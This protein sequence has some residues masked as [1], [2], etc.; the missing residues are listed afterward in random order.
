MTD[1]R[2]FQVRTGAG[3]EESRLNEDFIA[4][5]R[6][7]STPLLI[8]VAVAAGGFALYTR[9]T[10]AQQ[11]ELSVA[12]EELRAAGTGERPNPTSLIAVAEQYPKIKSVANLAR[13]QAADAYLRAVRQRV[14]LGA[15]IKAEDGSLLDAS[16]ILTDAL[17]EQYLNNAKEQYQLVLDATKNTPEKRL[18]AVA[19]AFGIAAVDES[20]GNF[21]DATAAYEETIRLSEAA[22][23][24]LH[25]EIAKKRLASLDTVKQIGPVISQAELP[26]PPA[27]PAPA[28]PA[29]LP[30]PAPAPTP[31]AVPAPTP[32]P[33]P[34]PT[35]EAAPATPAPAPTTPPTTPPD[36]PK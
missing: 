10:K 6:K 19:A 35:P 30:T 5:L 4:F 18:L 31:E 23:D 34:A 14:A 27:P 12:F 1:D 3:L 33:T 21:S 7:W 22:G 11:E 24:T 13:L 20:A 15:A 25:V 28:A 16:G 2:Q 29:I 36:A 8:V 9:Y 32:T 26:K 17:R